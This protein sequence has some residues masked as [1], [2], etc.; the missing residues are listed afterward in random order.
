[1]FCMSNE[2][3]NCIR[4]FQG[5]MIFTSISHVRNDGQDDRRLDLGRLQLNRT[6]HQP[7]KQLL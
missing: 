1:M 7:Q 2:N 6:V 5:K 3:K 4:Y